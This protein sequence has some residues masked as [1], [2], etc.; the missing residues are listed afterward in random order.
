M[1]EHTFEYEPA[2][3]GTTKSNDRIN[4]F[5]MLDVFPVAKRF[6]VVIAFAAYRLLVTAS[7]DRFETC[8]TFRVPTFAVV[9][10]RFVVVTELDALI[11]PVT[12]RVVAPVLPRMYKVSKF[13]G[14]VT[15]NAYPGELVV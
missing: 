3:A 12:F 8:Q 11:F 7:V 13:A 9:V 14:S 4:M 2:V 1:I 5:E 6:V 10:N 15:V